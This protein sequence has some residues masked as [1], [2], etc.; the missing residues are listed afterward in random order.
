M[1]LRPRGHL[2]GSGD[3]FGLRG[4]IAMLMVMDAAAHPPVATENFPAPNVNSA[5]AEKHGCRVLW[6]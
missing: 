6:K 2:A 1:I 5:E 4:G 3:I